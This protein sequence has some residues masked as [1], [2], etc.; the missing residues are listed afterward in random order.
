M[1]KRIKKVRQKEKS[2]ELTKTVL[3][4]C[5]GGGLIFLAGGC[6]CPKNYKQLMKKFTDLE[7]YSCSRVKECLKRLRM[8]DYIK[9]DENDLT[10]PIFLTK[11]GFQRHSVLSLRDKLKSL[12]MRKWDHIWRLVTYD[13]SED[14][15]VLRDK[16]RCQLKQIG[17]YQLQKNIFVIPFPI[18]KELE[19]LIEAHRLWNRV[20]VL[21]VANLGKHEDVVKDY[22]LALCKPKIKKNICL[23]KNK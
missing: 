9:Y 13:V 11:K 17:F 21:Q 8:Q 23:L 14:F 3:K 2:K 18:E 19:N 15:K 10:K 1:N 6:A 5:L 4:L 16:F 20:L 22:F 7:Q 12:T